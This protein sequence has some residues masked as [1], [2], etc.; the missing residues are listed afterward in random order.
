MP[1][2][3]NDFIRAGIEPLEHRG[4]NL[5][6]NE[7]N[8]FNPVDIA[9]KVYYHTKEG[10][11]VM[12]GLN[13]LR[14]LPYTKGLSKV[15]AIARFLGKA[16]KYV[17][18][19]IERGLKYAPFEKVTRNASPLLSTIGKKATVGNALRARAMVHA[20]QK[21]P[22]L[23]DAVGNVIK[24]KD[25]ESLKNAANIG[26]DVGYNFFPS[27]SGANPYFLSRAA[28][29]VAQPK[30]EE[31]IHTKNPL[32][33]GSAFDYLSLIRSL[34]TIKAKGGETKYVDTELTDA[35]IQDLIDEGYIVEQL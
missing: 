22:E 15:P 27:A 34:P 13:A 35:E 11:Y 12:A 5:M 4:G 26:I 33:G 14:A 7:I 3:Y 25:A 18:D 23:F 17:V 16:N 24:K 6:G 1:A 10:D 21:S 20:A 32:L 8:V 9:D 28:F 31:L 30:Q 29:N 2:N 19:P